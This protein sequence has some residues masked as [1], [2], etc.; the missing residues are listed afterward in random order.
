VRSPTGV[1]FFSSGLAN[2]PPNVEPLVTVRRG[3][4]R[5]AVF[6]L[7][8]IGKTEEACSSSGN[9]VLLLFRLRR[10][11]VCGGSPTSLPRRFHQSLRRNHL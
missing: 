7:V 5:N 10:I 1:S 8:V 4:S 3:T 2:G 9:D 11:L 6:F